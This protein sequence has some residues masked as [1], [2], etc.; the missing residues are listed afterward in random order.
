MAK[1]FQVTRTDG[2]TGKVTTCGAPTTGAKVGDLRN[3]MRMSA[4]VTQPG[5][6]NSYGIREV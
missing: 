4:R 3:R 5:N 6:S 1:R 2:R